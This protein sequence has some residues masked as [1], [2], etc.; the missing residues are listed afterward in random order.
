M[1]TLRV[2]GGGEW[3]R[4]DFFDLA[5]QLGILIF[6]D[7]TFACALYPTDPEFISNV[8]EEITQQVN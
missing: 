2:W 1:N 3:L 5:D 4:E 6:H 7:L 8:R